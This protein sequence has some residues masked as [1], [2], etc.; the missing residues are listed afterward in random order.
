MG[1]VVDDM[2]RMFR[3]GVAKVDGNIVLAV[4]VELRANAT[5]RYIL[6]RDLCAEFLVDHLNR[7]QPTV[8][9][10]A[11][12]IEERFPFATRNFTRGWACGLT[13]A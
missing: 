9:L 12:G 10:K 4:F 7:D 1:G 2:S 8:V 13:C 3:L 11:E 6:C 5:Q